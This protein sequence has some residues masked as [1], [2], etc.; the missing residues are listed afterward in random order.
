M[1]QKSP[2]PIGYKQ[3]IVYLDG[4]E[5]RGVGQDILTTDRN[6]QDENDAVSRL[7]LR[8]RRNSRSAL[9]TLCKCGRFRSPAPS[10]CGGFLLASSLRISRSR[11]RNRARNVDDSGICRFPVLGTADSAVKTS[12]FGRGALVKRTPFPSINDI[13]RDWFIVDA[14]DVVLGRI[15]T[16]VAHRLCG[17]HKPTYAPFLDTGDHVIVI[18]AGKVRLT[19]G[20]ETKKMYRRH[21]GYPGG[22]R[23][24]PAGK[25]KVDRPE[26]MIEEAVWGMLPKGSLGRKMFKKLK[27]YR[28]NEHPHSAQAPK[29]LALGA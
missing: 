28:G 5:E 16:E 21:T 4:F 18:N 11:N 9:T 8:E 20:K 13:K 25:M 19:G 6:R 3:V 23:E 17:K 2:Q 1:S 10:G 29:I 27:V 12:F 26:K 7:L 15:A 14:S 24:K 22:L